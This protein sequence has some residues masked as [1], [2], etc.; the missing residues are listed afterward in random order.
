LAS[1]EFL[2]LAIAVVGMAAFVVASL[3][4]ALGGEGFDL[5]TVGLFVFAAVMAI[6]FGVSSK[7]KGI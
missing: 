6:L 7:G 4:V 3:L 1:K 5:T 2:L